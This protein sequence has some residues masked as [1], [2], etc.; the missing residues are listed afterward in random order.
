[1]C[2]LQFSCALN[3]IIKHCTIKI[4]MHVS[5]TFEAIDGTTVL[6]Y[7]PEI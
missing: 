1:M 3:Y 4:G 7:V 6:C 5:F 2:I